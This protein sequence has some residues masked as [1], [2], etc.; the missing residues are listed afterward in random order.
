M[1]TIV[2]ISI[3]VCTLSSTH[4]WKNTQNSRSTSAAFLLAIPTV[5]H[6]F[7]RPHISAELG[8]YGSGV[9]RRKK[10]TVEARWLTTQRELQLI[11]EKYGN[12]EN[13]GISTFGEKSREIGEKKQS[14]VIRLGS[15]QMAPMKRR[16]EQG[17]A[18]VLWI[19]HKP[20][21]LLLELDNNNWTRMMLV[22]VLLKPRT[23]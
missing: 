18:T 5:F 19:V 1:G 14:K 11:E 16:Y 21:T 3:I 23:I 17:L 15:N 6:L 13:G 20:F 8:Q 22:R 12:R 9:K 10:N 7:E 4:L 2:N